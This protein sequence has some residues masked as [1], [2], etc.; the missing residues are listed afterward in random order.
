MTGDRQPSEVVVLRSPLR[1]GGA[2]TTEIPVVRYQDL[3]GAVLA[4]C[5]DGTHRM[6]DV[7]NIKE[8]RQ[9]E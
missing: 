9:H 5:P 7:E 2:E 1:Y 8:V 6:L 3:G 4:R